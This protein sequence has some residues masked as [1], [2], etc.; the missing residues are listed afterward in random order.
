ML[1]GAVFA[2]ALSSYAEVVRAIMALA[3]PDCIVTGY[4]QPEHQVHRLQK[5]E[6]APTPLVPL[7]ILRRE[8]GYVC[9]AGIEVP[10]ELRVF[11]PQIP[12]REV[13]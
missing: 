8:R 12:V 6:A 5:R 7:F 3:L 1:V 11:R 2:L 13:S 10:L 4:V 9:N